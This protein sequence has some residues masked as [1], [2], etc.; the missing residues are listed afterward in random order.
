MASFRVTAQVS[1]FGVQEIHKGRR[2]GFRHAPARAIVAGGDRMM[3]DLRLSFLNPEPSLPMSSY[4]RKGN[5]SH[6]VWLLHADY[7]R[8]L[9]IVFLPEVEQDDGGQRQDPA[10]D[11]ERLQDLAQENE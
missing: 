1:G 2:R 4:L 7:R 3:N 8:R 11:L 6:L 5:S 9:F 10:Q